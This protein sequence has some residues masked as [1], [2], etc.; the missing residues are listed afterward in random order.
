MTN[1]EKTC[2]CSGLA[3]YSRAIE[4]NPRLSSAYN[5]RGNIIKRETGDLDGAIADFDRAI[6]LDSG[7]AAFYNNRGLARREH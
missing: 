4:I 6:Q 2:R 3:D 1:G 5:N 7:N